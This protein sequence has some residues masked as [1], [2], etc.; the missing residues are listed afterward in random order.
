MARVADNQVQSTSWMS[1]STKTPRKQVRVSMSTMFVADERV[2]EAAAAMIT[3][4]NASVHV[5]LIG[6]IS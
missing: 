2:G 3:H 4:S 5:C 1:K 6:F